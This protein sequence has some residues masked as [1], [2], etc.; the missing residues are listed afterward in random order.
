MQNE[1][2]GVAGLSWKGFAGE[3]QGEKIHFDDLLAAEEFE[4]HADAFAGGQHFHHG[5]FHAA[6][7]AVGELD[8]LSLGDERADGQDFLFALLGDFL[9]E[10]LHEIIRDFRNLVAEADQAADARAI[11]HR[12]LVGAEVEAGQ[13]V[14]GKECLDPPDLPAAG[15]LAVA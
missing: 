2:T 9:A 12:A 11:H 8:F 3:E 15:G 7:G 4:K 14:A 10:Q 5:R 1:Q 13:Q 6:E